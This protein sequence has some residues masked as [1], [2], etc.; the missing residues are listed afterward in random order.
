VLDGTEGARY[1]YFP[2]ELKHGCDLFGM[3]TRLLFGAVIACAGG[4][5]SGAL[6]AYWHGLRS[7]DWH[8]GP[9]GGTSNWYSKAP[10]AGAPPNVP[11]GVAIFSPGA[12]RTSVR[13]SEPA[14]I[15]ELLFRA[16][17]EQYTFLIMRARN[18]RLVIDRGIRNFAATTPRFIVGAGPAQ[19]IFSPQA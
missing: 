19:P 11:D 3:A 6:D 8:D 18:S 2:R 16:G 15:D 7:A 9:Q 1:A 13:V 10:P 4:G 12:Q 14:S 5:E 17:R